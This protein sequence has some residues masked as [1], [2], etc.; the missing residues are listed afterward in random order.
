M[1][2][3]GYILLFLTLFPLFLTAQSQE[4]LVV[5]RV[6]ERHT[7]TP[8]AS[9]NIHFKNTNIGTTSND[10]GYFI[11][12]SYGQE[13]V[14]VFSSVGYKTRELIVRAGVPNPFLHVAMEEQIAWLDGVVVMPGVNPA[15]EWMRKIRLQ[16]RANDITR[17]PDYQAESTVQDLVLLSRVQQRALS[18]R[19][20]EQ[21]QAGNL[22][23]ADTALLIPLY[24]AEST[25]LHTNRGS[26]ELSRN[27]F[28]T[29]ETAENFVVRILQGI[30][31]ELNFYNNS[32]SVFGRS[33]ISPLANIGNSFY[34]F[35]LTDSIITEHGKQYEIRFRS[36]NP[37]NLAFNGTFRFDAN[38]LALTFI[39]ARLPRLANINFVQ[40]LVIRQE[41]KPL[42]YNRWALKTS[43]M[44]MSLSYDI[45]SSQN[46]NRGTELWVHQSK[47]MNIPDSIDKLIQNF[48]MSEYSI[49]TLESR[50]QAL[51]N[52]PMM[53][54]AKWLA[55]TAITGYARAG[56]IDVGPLL[57]L[58]RITDIEGLRVNI[59]LRTNERLSPHFSVGGYIGY[60]FR[61]RQFKHSVFGQFRLPTNNRN[62]FEIRYTND[63]RRI[64]YNYNNFIMNENVWNFNNA[65][66][67][68]T[69]LS[70]TS[71]QKLSP[72]R[73]WSFSL[74]HDWS[75]NIESTAFFRRNKLLSCK[76]MPL[77]VAGTELSSISQQ[78]FSLSTRFSFDDRK[79]DGFMQRIYIRNNKPVIYGTLE[80]GQYNVGGQTGNYAKILG[81]MRQRVRFSTGTWNYIAE[82][83]WI[84]GRV[85]F[86]FLEMPAGS[87]SGGISLFRF[88]RMHYAEFGFDR[89]ISFN[90]EFLFNGIVFNH[91]PLVNR[92]NL[93]ELVALKMIVGNVS[94]RHREVLDF[95]NPSLH[96]HH[97]HPFQNP[98]IEAS[99]GISNILRV[100][101]VQMNWRF[102][103]H[104]EGIVPRRMSAGVRIDF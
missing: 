91:I 5:G 56:K 94:D 66:I 101:T 30:H 16:R 75:R 4:T 44:T 86:P 55:N 11:L 45:I 69:L 29:S 48:A 9:V 99:V 60:G 2:I 38:S 97:L 15:L 41:F 100:L 72:R 63:F 80:F 3:K 57:Q 104:Y 89:F 64:D 65:N 54:T 33:I 98:Y 10:D 28:S 93:R 24:M 19:L 36:R 18:R 77:S 1:N 78:S 79:I 74:T 90:N 26:T 51:D 82:A 31:P 21:L 43:V 47:M 23:E 22:A 40:D 53:R 87:Q 34:D 88:N 61:S 68:N 14:V 95:P 62:I 6:F 12:R 46:V 83:G 35:F 96:P 103:N 73:D 25:H 67:A 20:F 81:S 13:R 39:E 8:M 71:A 70:F 52:T 58:A 59:P 37:R 27:L 84:V 32:V 50:M 17:F 42:P 7:G 85:P 92:L 76:F 49:E 102:T